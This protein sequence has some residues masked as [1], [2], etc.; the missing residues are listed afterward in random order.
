[1]PVEPSAVSTVASGLG[2]SASAVTRTRAPLQTREGPS[3]TR[4]R[5]PRRAAD[6]THLVAQPLHVRL[7]QLLAV[8]QALDPA[9]RAWGMPGRLQ[10]GCGARSA[11]TRPTSSMFVSMV[12]A[13]SSAAKRAA[14]RIRC[15][16]WATVETVGRARSLTPV[17]WRR[18][19]RRGRGAMTL[20]PDY[21]AESIGKARVADGRGGSTGR[22]QG[23]AAAARSWATR[24]GSQG[25]SGGARGAGGRKNG[26]EVRSKA[27]GA[28]CCFAGRRLCAIEIMA[29]GPLAKVASSN[30][31]PPAAQSQ[32]PAASL[33]EGRPLLLFWKKIVR[34]R[35]KSQDRPK[36]KYG[37]CTPYL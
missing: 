36:S 13:S 35:P 19:R 2:P 3:G 1:M 25:I 12:V 27:G 15:P 7:G 14:V 33:I 17:G 8:H 11:G 4:L 22:G 21:D 20:L 16:S 28:P 23:S 6:H 30:P 10:A 37:V 26:I 18:R 9:H 31:W 29:C 32:T 34:P 24:T 5:R